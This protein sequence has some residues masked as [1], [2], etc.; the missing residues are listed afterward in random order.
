[1]RVVRGHVRR[2]FVH[3]G[4]GGRG[5][6]AARLMSLAQLRRLPVTQNGKLTGMI[7]VADFARRG[8]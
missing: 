1:M 6:K 3:R 2:R 8:N 5:K 4:R 7:S